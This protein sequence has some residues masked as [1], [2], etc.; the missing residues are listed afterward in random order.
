[1]SF[2]KIIVGAMVLLVS[3][4][5]SGFAAKEPARAY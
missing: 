1:M 2:S 4:A 3:R 5:W